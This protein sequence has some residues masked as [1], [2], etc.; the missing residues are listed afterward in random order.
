M[1]EHPEHAPRYKLGWHNVSL[2]VLFTPFCWMWD[3][4]VENSTLDLYLGPIAIGIGWYD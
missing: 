1:T 4:D 2:S 3:I